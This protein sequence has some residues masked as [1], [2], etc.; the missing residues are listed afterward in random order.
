MGRF[1][2]QLVEKNIGEPHVGSY[3]PYTPPHAVQF[4]LLLFP[5]LLCCPWQ[6]AVSFLHSGLGT[7]SALLS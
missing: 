3:E 6:E 2:A 4:Q 7:A 5:S 1:L